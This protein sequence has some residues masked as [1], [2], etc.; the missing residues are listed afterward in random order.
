MKPKTFYICGVD[1]DYEL[2]EIT[3]KVYPSV[4]KLKEAQNCT[5]ECG[6]VKITIVDDNV[7]WVQKQN[8]FG[9]DDG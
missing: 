2:G 3:V 9:A 6:I 5:D 4:K 1:L 8:L 7:E